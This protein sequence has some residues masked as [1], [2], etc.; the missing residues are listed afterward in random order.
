MTQQDTRYAVR[1][2]GTSPQV[3]I[4]TGVSQGLM[5]V[6][7]PPPATGAS[8]YDFE[9]GTWVPYEPPVDLHAHLSAIRRAHETGGV[10]VTIGS[11]TIEVATDQ[12]G[13]TNLLGARVAAQ[14]VPG[15]ATVWSANNG[16][17]PLDGAGIIALSD[18]VLA[19]INGAFVAQDVVAEDIDAGTLTT[20][21]EVEAAFAA[22]VAGV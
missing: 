11:D 17:F 12:E 5:E 20:P 13:R 10:T 3:F 14:E 7:T 2:D 15:F 4:G 21:A 16:R 6:P 22:A 18:A 9:T 19:H 8:A 1:P